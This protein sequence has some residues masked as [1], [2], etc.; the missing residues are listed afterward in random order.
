MSPYF[1]PFLFLF[2]AA[3]FVIFPVELNQG[4]DRPKIDKLQEK[5]VVFLV[6]VVIF[7]EKNIT[8]FLIVASFIE[9]YILKASTNYIT[10]PS[11]FISNSSIL[12]FMLD[13]WS[14]EM[15]E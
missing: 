8:Y 1:W 10:T 12:S 11:L 9:G 2:A 15:H 5:V 3:V 4:W 6:S 14:M 13:A 7:M